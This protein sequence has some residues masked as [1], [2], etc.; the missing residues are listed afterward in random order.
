MFLFFYFPAAKLYYLHREQNITRRFFFFFLVCLLVEP[1]APVLTG[2]ILNT[3]TDISL[4][5]HLLS[6]SI[7]S[8]LHITQYNVGSGVSLA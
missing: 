2:L 6:V 7:F 5:L 3:Q 1:G 4:S 8:V